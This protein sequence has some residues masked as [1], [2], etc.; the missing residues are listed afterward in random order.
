M[1][2]KSL[3]YIIEQVIRAVLAHHE[4]YENPVD[5]RFSPC[6][7]SL[8]QMTLISFFEFTEVA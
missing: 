3:S 6:R 7:S 5:K 2:P 1:N 4:A 8:S